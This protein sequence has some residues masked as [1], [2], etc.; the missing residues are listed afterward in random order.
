MN[1]D[2]WVN[3]HYGST[4]ISFKK[5]FEL[6]FTPFHGLVLRDYVGEYENDI[7]FETHDYC[8]T[9]IDYLVKEERFSV[10]VRHVWNRPVTDETVDDVIETFTNTN[11][12]RRDNTDIDNFKAFMKAEYERTK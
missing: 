5:T 9:Q 4:T 7:R 6:P 12:E 1:T 11:W 10:D 2:V 8:R 3:F